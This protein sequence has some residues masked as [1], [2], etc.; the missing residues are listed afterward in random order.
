MK[1]KGYRKKGRNLLSKTSEKGGFPPIK[2]W[3]ATYDKGQK[4]AIDIWPGVYEGMPHLRYQ[5]RVGQVI[6]KRGRCY[7]IGIPLDKRTAKIMV[8]PVHIRPLA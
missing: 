8:S 6:E 5:G 3:L 2:R 1:A 4:I 7:V